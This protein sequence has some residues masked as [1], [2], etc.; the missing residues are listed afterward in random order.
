MGLV[1]ANSGFSMECFNRFF[2][3]SV[4]TL[5]FMCVCTRDY[6]PFTDPANARASVFAVSFKN[7]DTINIFSTETLSLKIEVRELVDSVVCA[8]LHNRRNPDKIVIKDTTTHILSA[9]PYTLLFSFCDTGKASISISTFRHGIENIVTEYSLYCISPLNPV[10]VNGYYGKSI[11][12]STAPV[13]DKDVMYHWDL[14]NSLV[15]NSPNPDTT[16]KVLYF[17]PLTDPWQVWV[18]D[19]N[20]NHKSPCVKFLPVL[21]DTFHPTITCLNLNPGSH[22]DSVIITGDSVFYF[23]ILISDGALTTPNYIAFVNDSGF[24]FSQGSQFV[25]IIDNMEKIRTP[26]SFTIK[27]IANTT[28]QHVSQKSFYISFDSTVGKGSGVNFIILDP[29]SKTT[30]SSISGKTILGQFENFTPDT[31]RAIVKLLINGSSPQSP[32]SV[33]IGPTTTLASPVNWS[34]PCLLTKDTNDVRLIA[35]SQTGD[36]LG[37]GLLTIYY[38]PNQLDMVPPVMKVYINDKLID[39]ISFITFTPFDKASI[40][41]IAYDEASSVDSVTVNHVKLPL[42]SDMPGS[43]WYD[44][45]KLN[46]NSQIDSI[47]ISAYDRNKNRTTQFIRV[48]INHPPQFFTYPN[49]PSYVI[50]G[51]METYSYQGIDAD[52]DDD[53]SL[54]LPQ[55]VSGFSNIPGKNSFTWIPQEKDI[56]LQT[57]IFTLSDG[58]EYAQ[59]STKCLIMKA[60]NLPAPVAFTFLPDSIPKIL[61][62]GKDTLNLLLVNKDDTT[63]DPLVFLVNTTAADRQISKPVVNKTDRRLLWAPTITD[64]G[65]VDLWITVT[66]KFGRSDT[67]GSTIAVVPPNRPCKLQ[68]TYAIQFTNNNELDLSN[69]TKPETLFVFVNDPDP[70]Y[71]EKLTATIRWPQSQS[72]I[73]I[74]DTRKFMVILNPKTATSKLKDTVHII[75]TDKAAHSDSATFYISYGSL[76]KLIALNT[77]AG[78]TQISASVLNFPLLVHL[79]KSNFPFGSSSGTGA[80]LRFGKVDGT[81]LPFE[82]DHWDSAGGNATVWVLVDTVFANSNSPFLRMTWGNTLAAGGP[83]GVAVFDTALGYLGVWHMNDASLG[84]NMNSAQKAFN[85]T[86]SS[87]SNNQTLLSGSGVISSA[88]SLTTNSFLLAGNLPTPQQVTISAWVYP[89]SVSSNGKI[90]CKPWTSYTSPFQIYSLELPPVNTTSAQFHVGLSGQ[91]SFYAASNNTLPLN[92]WTHL[93]GTYDGSALRLYV[94]GSQISST[95]ISPV[96]APSVP[97]NNQ[98]WT[99]GSWDLTTGEFFSGKLDEVRICRGAFSSDYIKLSYENQKPGSSLVTFTTP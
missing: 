78:G 61:E 99:I 26:R 80:D 31:V 65:M 77:S 44:T 3:F 17:Q 79:D 42:S 10:P 53:I 34:I 38:K 55:N 21:Q 71:A 16:I 22:N 9:T 74:D 39:T 85:T 70:L 12:L 90:I 75:V 30:T 64:T 48:K 45:V 83:N 14:G 1:L 19:I 96:P 58:Y 91:Y 23:Q 11:K 93:T 98:S 36:S 6:N 7:N 76:E 15:I 82:I 46:N 59:Y 41:I 73:G 57:L 60:T 97:T 69:S 37:T 54:I 18:S 49:I 66:D 25:K 89:V 87:T 32:D 88:D 33:I 40:R 92:T 13:V 51:Q 5:F 67:V 94:N 24:S 81:T 95:Q 86:L 28:A 72:V 43:I 47:E 8:A 68:V 20:D 35:L 50:I 56:G 62:V 84:Q 27:A 4:M 29:S 2:L 52:P 63:N